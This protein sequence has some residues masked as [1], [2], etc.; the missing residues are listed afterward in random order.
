M[1]DLRPFQVHKSLQILGKF[2]QFS[3]KIY[4]LSSKYLQQKTKK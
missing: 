2:V 1:W 3:D 4:M